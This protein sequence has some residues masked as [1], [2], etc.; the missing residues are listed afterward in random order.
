MLYSGSLAVLKTQGV[1]LLA[2]RISPE[3]TDCA[4]Y[5]SHIPSCTAPAQGRGEKGSPFRTNALKS[6]MRSGEGI[7]FVTQLKL[8]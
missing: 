8:D 2:S 1:H 4:R 3:C 6:A 5:Q 7:M